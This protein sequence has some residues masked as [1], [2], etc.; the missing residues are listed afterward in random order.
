MNIDNV[1]YIDEF[2]KLKYPK[3]EMLIVTSGVLALFG[4]RKNKDIDV[5]VK[6]STFRKMLLDKSFKFTKSI[7]KG[8]LALSSKDSHIE[9]FNVPIVGNLME[10]FN[11][12]FTV[13]G[14]LFQSLEDLIKWKKVLNRS[15]DYLDI[16][17]LE[18]YVENYFTFLGR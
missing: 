15:K 7:T 4:L 8:G 12:A 1:R 9:L 11:R 3:S 14:V 18:E 17:L 10:N 13:N 2:R 5:L 16:K 6:P